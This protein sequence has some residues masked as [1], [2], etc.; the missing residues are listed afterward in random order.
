MRPPAARLL[1]ALILVAVAGGCG[2]SPRKAF[3]PAGGTNVPLSLDDHQPG[4]DVLLNGRGP[5]RVLVDTGASPA[6][7]LSP[8]LAKELGLGRDLGYVRLRAANG[9]WVRAGRTHM[10][11]LRLGAAVFRGVPAVILDVGAGDF[12]GVIGMGLFDRGVV[13]F[14]FPNRRLSLRPGTLSREDPDA[15]AAPFAYGIPM[16]PVSPPLRQGRRTVDVLL[17]TGSNG[18]LVLPDSLRDELVTD[19]GFAGRAVADT[20]GGTREI[21]LVRLRGKLGLGRYGADDVVVG[22]A[23]GRGAIGTPALRD[24][25]VSVDQRSRRVRLKLVGKQRGDE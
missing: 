23:P 14:D 7:A 9:Q 21:E 15:F 3:I 5:Y 16:V 10:D 4:V 13:T 12:A 8:R 17:D 2:F 1:L 22:L 20:L 11:S 24:F 18:G 6:I 19:P 25:E